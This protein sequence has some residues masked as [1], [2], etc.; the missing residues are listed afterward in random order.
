MLRDIEAA[1]QETDPSED[2]VGYRALYLEKFR[3]LSLR[4]DTKK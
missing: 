3:L 2:P 1:L 4:P